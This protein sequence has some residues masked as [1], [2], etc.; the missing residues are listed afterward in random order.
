MGRVPT[1]TSKK[2][3]KQKATF[4][5]NPKV[6]GYWILTVLVSIV[7]L[8]SGAGNFMR[9]EEMKASMTA[10]GYPIYFMSILGA[11]K[12]LGAIA[13]L[14]P[15]FPRLKEWAY[16]GV[17]FGMTGAFLSH[18]LAGDPVAKAIP[19][20]VIWGLAMGSWALRPA[21]RKLQG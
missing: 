11:W 14:A 8:G 5:K 7:L 19:P 1:I 13:L 6:I 16:A 21:S 12:M 20:L 2:K 4:M 9:A 18:L 10:L 3:R 17:T 15:K